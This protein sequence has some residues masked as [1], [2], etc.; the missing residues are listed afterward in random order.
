MVNDVHKHGNA[1][2]LLA[3]L[4]GN[5][6]CARALIDAQ[7]ELK[8]T[9]REAYCAD[10]R[11]QETSLVHASERKPGHDQLHASAARGHGADPRAWLSRS[12]VSLEFACERHQLFAVVLATSHIVEF[13]ALD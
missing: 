6:E 5:L 1:K 3:C 2:F 8:M 9:N 7:A 10:C 12:V 4:P 13:A 11:L